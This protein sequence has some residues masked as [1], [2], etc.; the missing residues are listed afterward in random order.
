M[1]KKLPEGF[2]FELKE[3]EEIKQV[4]EFPDYWV[5]NYGRVFSYKNAYKTRKGWRELK[6][7]S[8]TKHR[9]LDCRISVQGKTLHFPVHRYVCKYFC[10]GYAEGLVVNHI[11]GDTTNNYYKN[12]EWV[13][14][15]EN[16]HKSYISSKLDAT[17]NYYIIELYDSQGKYV[18]KFKG[19][20]KMID[21]IKENNLDCSG[22]SLFAYGVS[23]GYTIK[24]YREVRNG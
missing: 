2:P 4:I 8:D 6:Q 22:L 9:Y 12:L 13:S 16:I 23:R 5:S 19:K 1:D 10:L 14:Q 24:K 20:F 21:Y 15:K 17:R 7:Y 11:D 3:D 18:D